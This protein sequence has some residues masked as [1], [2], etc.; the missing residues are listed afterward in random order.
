MTFSFT[1]PPLSLPL[2][3][4]TSVRPPPPAA[5]VLH[6]CAPPR[7]QGA[8]SCIAVFAIS[9]PAAAL[10]AISRTMLPSGGCFPAVH[11]VCEPLDS[12]AALCGVGVWCCCRSCITR[13][14]RKCLLSERVIMQMLILIL[15]LLLRLL[16]L[17]IRINHRVTSCLCAHF[18]QSYSIPSGNSSSAA[19]CC[20][21]VLRKGQMLPSFLD[22]AHVHHFCCVRSP[23]ACV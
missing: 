17:H 21:I 19:V 20:F 15:I 5:P 3:R 12:P 10:A 4:L 8:T 14:D 6:T 13:L 11:V 1:V 7:N 9:S 16:L 22:A 2:C 23:D 18:V